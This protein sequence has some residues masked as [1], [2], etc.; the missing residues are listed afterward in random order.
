MINSN[1]GTITGNLTVN[2]KLNATASAANSLTYLILNDGSGSNKTGYRLIAT[3]PIKAWTNV[4]GIFVIKSRH[5]GGGVLC[6]SIGCNSET[7]SQANV[8]AEIKYHGPIDSGN[9][10]YNDSFFVYVSS[11]GANA[12]LFWKYTDYNTTCIYT[13]ASDFSLSNGTWMETINTATYGAQKAS[14]HRTAYIDTANHLLF[15]NGNELWIE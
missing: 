11:N 10:I 6:V 5:S 14:V 1:G 3:I 8:Y 9:I 13:I 4:R 2:G 12:Y 7:V 15:P